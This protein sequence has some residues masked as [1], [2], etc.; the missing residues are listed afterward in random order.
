MKIRTKRTALGLAVA[1]AI[2]FAPLQIAQTADVQDATI[3]DMAITVPMYYYISTSA[4]PQNGTVIVQ[5]TSV[6][7]DLFTLTMDRGSYSVTNGT[8]QFFLAQADSTFTANDLSWVISNATLSNSGTTPDDIL[9]VDVVANRM[10]DTAA[11]AAGTLNVGDISLTIT[12]T[13][14]TG[15]VAGY[16]HQAGRDSNIQTNSG[17]ATVGN[18]SVSVTGGTLGTGMGD[19]GFT[20]AYIASTDQ[21]NVTI[22]NTEGTTPAVSVSLSGANESSAVFG[23]RLRYNTS[24]TL[25]INNGIDVS[26]S[27]GTEGGS[28]YGFSD[29]ETNVGT[30]TRITGNISVDVEGA[31]EGGT[32]EISSHLLSGI[33]ESGSGSSL[34]MT[35]DV[36]VTAYGLVEQTTGTIGLVEV[37]GAFV[38]GDTTTATGTISAATMNLTGNISVYLEGIADISSYVAGLETGG[39]ATV[40]GDITVTN[41]SEGGDSTVISGDIYGVY[42]TAGEAEVGNVVVALGGP[43]ANLG[44]TNSIYGT[45]STGGTI[46]VNG[47]RTLYFGYTT[48]ASGNLVGAVDL[49]GNGVVFTSDANSPFTGA[50]GGFDEVVVTSGSTLY[51]A[52]GETVLDDPTDADGVEASAGTITLAADT[53]TSNKPTLTV[54]SGGTLV[55][56]TLADDAG[57]VNNYGG[58][59]ADTITVGTATN[60]I[61]GVVNN[62][63]TMVA[64]STQVTG[65]GIYGGELDNHENATFT[66]DNLTTTATTSASIK[67]VNDGIMNILAESDDSSIDSWLQNTGTVNIGTSEGSGGKTVTIKSTY[68]VIVSSGY[69]NL[70]ENADLSVEGVL[71]NSGFLVSDS[72]ITSASTSGVNIAVSG[73]INNGNIF[74]VY[75]YVSTLGVVSG[76]F[77]NQAGAS[78]VHGGVTTVSDS[79]QI[80]NDSTNTMQFYDL[81]VESGSVTGGNIVGLSGESTTTLDVGT[82]GTVSSVVNVIFKSVTNE[83]S[84]AATNLMLGLTGEDLAS[85]YPDSNGTLTNSGTVSADNLYAPSG[86]TITN[87]G[88]G[89]ITVGSLFA[90]TDSGTAVGLTNVTYTQNNSAHLYITGEAE[91]AGWFTGSE[92]IIAGGYL[93]TS[94]YAD[95]PTATVVDWEATTASG[96]TQTTTATTLGSNTVTISLEGATMPSAGQVDS[97]YSSGLTVVT[98][99]A[100]TADTLVTIETGGVLVVDYIDLTAATDKTLKIDGGALQTS[101]IQIFEDVALEA[102][103]VDATEPGTVEVETDVYATAVG[104]VR[105]SVLTGMSGTSGNI[106]FTDAHFDTALLT[107]VSST[108]SDAGYNLT[109]NYLGELTDLFTIDTAQE[110]EAEAAEY[111]T[112]PGIVLN[113]TTLYSTLDGVDVTALTIG[114]TG[115]NFG[116][117]M[118]FKDIAVAQSVEIIGGKELVLVGDA[119]GDYTYESYSL[120]SD[121][122]D[123]GTITVTNGTFTFGTLG[124]ADSSVGYV[125]EV[126]VTSNGALNAKNG[127]F[128]AWTISNEGAVTVDASAVLHTSSLTG[129]A[130]AITN[131][132]KLYVEANG[133]TAEFTIGTGGL[134]NSGTLTATDVATTYA[135]GN[136]TNTGTATY[137]DLQIASGV[138][139]DNSGTESGGTLTVDSGTH[140]NSGTSTWDGYVLTGDDAEGTN[141]GTLTVNETLTVGAGTTL[142]NTGTLAATAATTSVTGTLDN[143][144]EADFGD[145]IVAEGGEVINSSDMSIATLT[146]EAGSAITNSDTMSVTGQADIAG[147]LTN[148]GDATFTTLNLSEGASTN[149]KTITADNVTIASGSLE[150]SGT[151]TNSDTITVSGGDVTNTGTATTKKLTVTG[152]SFTTSDTLTISD[153]L[154]ISGGT[155][156]VA[157]GTFTVDT[158][159][160][161]GGTVYLGSSESVSL[162]LNLKDTTIGS[163]VYVA[164]SSQLSFGSGGLDWAES[165]MSSIGVSASGSMLV[166]RSSVTMAEGGSIVVGSTSSSDGLYFAGDST[167]VVDVDSIGSS[168]YSSSEGDKAS[169]AVFITEASG[170]TATIDSGAQLVLVGSLTKEGRY[171]ITQGYSATLS[172]WTDNFTWG[173]EDGT[174]YGLDS[175][176]VGWELAVK[177]DS[178][179]DVYVVAVKHDDVSDNYDV[180]IPN[181]VN[182]DL[183]DCS[184]SSSASAVCGILRDDSLTKEEKEKAIN[185]MSN[186]LFAGGVMATTM[187]DA[188]A[189][190]DSVVNHLTMDSDTFDRD[191]NLWPW[192][193]AGNLWIDVLG[194]W[195]HGKH[196]EATKISG[197]S[198]RANSYGAIIGYDQK[199]ENRPIVLGAAFSFSDGELKSHGGVNKTKNEYQTYGLSFFG[200]Y[201]PSPYYNIIGSLH[202]FHNSADVKQHSSSGKV[203]AQ[204]QTNMLA[205]GLRAETT[206]KAGQ[207]NIVPHVETRYLYGKTS[208]FTTKLDGSNLWRTNPKGTNTVQ[209]PVG[210]AFRG[211]VKTESG[212]NIRPRAD[213]TAIPQVGSTKQKSVV[214]SNGVSDTI[215]GQFMGKFG[216]SVKVGFQADKGNTTV[217]LRYGFLGGTKGRADHSVMLQGRYRF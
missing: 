88:T 132:G 169:S 122:E 111:V 206:I 76:V 155:L 208:K 50:F 136:I 189:A 124:A 129:E 205:V 106:V 26:V 31:D 201:S 4:A 95:A 153:T 66:T 46:T 149:T 69:L 204:I 114:E 200:N 157:K 156:D 116:I 168:I 72:S 179:G 60:T 44:D 146:A 197:Y 188:T 115:A 94:E 102:I 53:V 61:L 6:D 192:D 186:L 87:S 127:E 113:N 49:D 150:N 135:N 215:D 55:V 199:L 36:S 158:A 183:N 216:G 171:D 133:G 57:T 8:A 89:T 196:L 41:I 5:T 14:I 24:G 184:S 84:I 105:E 99:E 82:S 147:T 96:S 19:T 195:Q 137:Q 172:G 126:D 108:L 175:S 145:V 103:L 166:M 22:G 71:N 107:S 181:I 86:S 100:V 117:S 217:G 80:V 73:T 178:D 134:I 27:G 194:S 98:T 16:L 54:Q 39:T 159:A 83:G 125:G 30:S 78:F 74:E 25:V 2:V 23:V 33:F 214:W 209:F 212:W 40:S 207:V 101:L 143:D 118:G 138:T 120:L 29:D 7:N 119:T 45:L 28:T 173:T 211:D 163:Q 97:T 190:F 65:N 1:S 38:T 140:T 58:I 187:T 176:G 81:E 92:L 110:L 109:V 52:A 68:G 213:I 35:G 67:V 162:D 13:D 164:N 32:S 43:A 51:I 70:Y 12:D 128:A 77:N 62:Y 142:T 170:A 177:T 20:G 17:T 151:L 79:G 56:P 112:D 210:V 198:Y 64:T 47:T 21:F 185:S 15:E 123:G 130:G 9:Y 93:D 203:A 37:Q 63:G 167:L 10:T 42:Q 202:W 165:A 161:N 180:S 34:T 121:A 91:S 11:G 139:S 141:S 3:Y 154:E 191:G 48:D 18:I 131:N 144:G 152:G 85:I 90:S 104:D 193:K 59:T 182:E 75:S 160:L 148:S 174:V